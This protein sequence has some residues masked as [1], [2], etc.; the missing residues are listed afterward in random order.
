MSK[1]RHQRV[2]QTLLELFFFLWPSHEKVTFQTLEVL[3]TEST[4]LFFNQILFQKKKVEG[5]FSHENAVIGSDKHL[6]T[7]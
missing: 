2:L 5:L 3:G 4:M 7:V 6:S 1:V